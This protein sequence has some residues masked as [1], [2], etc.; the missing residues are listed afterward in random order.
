MTFLKAVPILM[1]AAAREVAGNGR[2]IRQARTEEECALVREAWIVAF[3]KVYR[4]E[5]NYNDVFNSGL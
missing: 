4:R 2:G 3:Q 1:A 5:P